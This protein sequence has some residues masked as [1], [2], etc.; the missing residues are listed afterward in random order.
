M[1]VCAIV[2]L[3]T[4]SVSLLRLPWPTRYSKEIVTSFRCSFSDASVVPLQIILCGRDRP[5]AGSKK[6]YW[7]R[8]VQAP[9]GWSYR[10]RIGK[11]S[12]MMWR[13]RYVRAYSSCLR[14]RYARCSM[15]LLGRAC[16]H[17]TRRTRI[18]LL[19]A[20]FRRWPSRKGKGEVEG[21]IVC[22]LT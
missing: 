7:A 17:G 15:L 19:K 2:S 20:C 13:R 4:G 8:T 14:G 11:A 3:L 22:I 21:I 12:G 18:R 5:S 16:R 10:G 6:W 9:I 1:Q